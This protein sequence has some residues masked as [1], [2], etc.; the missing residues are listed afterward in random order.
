MR[1]ITTGLVALSI[2]AGLGLVA[3]S[4]SAVP[5]G[6]V[7]VCHNGHLISVS[8]NALSAHL[9]HGDGMISCDGDDEDSDSG[10]DSD[11]GDGTR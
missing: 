10:G 1:K 4:A 5:T 8:L 3:G 9:A 11:D 7:M 6:K 2:M